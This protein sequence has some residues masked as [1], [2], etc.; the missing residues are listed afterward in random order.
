[1]MASQGNTTEYDP[2]T[3]TFTTQE[4]KD[5]DADI[6]ADLDDDSFDFLIPE[7]DPDYISVDMDNI[8]LLGGEKLYNLTGDDDT[9]STHPASSS[10]ISFSSNSIHHYDADS[11]ADGSDPN[12]SK[13]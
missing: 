11:C 12:H 5:F 4:Q 1:M 6:Q 2:K 13:I 10:M 7:S 3:Q 8:K 9:A